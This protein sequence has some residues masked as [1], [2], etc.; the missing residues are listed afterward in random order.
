[1]FPAMQ[2]FCIHPYTNRCCKDYRRFDHT[3]WDQTH[4]LKNT[5]DVETIFI[6]K[7]LIWVNCI[8]SLY[9]CNMFFQA[10]CIFYFPTQ[11]LAWYGAKDE[12]KSPRKLFSYCEVWRSRISLLPSV[13]SP[14]YREYFYVHTHTYTSTFA[15]CITLSVQFM[16]RVLN[17]SEYSCESTQHHVIFMGKDLRQRLQWIFNEPKN[18]GHMALNIKDSTLHTL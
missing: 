8:R 6:S 15:F 9:I 7:L 1:M 5:W 13:A 17:A 3:K 18:S 2:H 12:Q 11:L 10:T 14:L 16:T 4:I